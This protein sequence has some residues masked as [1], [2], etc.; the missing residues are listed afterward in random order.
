MMSRTRAA[1][2]AVMM[3][4]VLGAGLMAGSAQA[5]T[6]SFTYQLSQTANIP[7]MPIL[8]LRAGGLAL[9]D[10]NGDGLMDAVA[11]GTYVAGVAIIPNGGPET[12]INAGAGPA[13]VAAADLDGDG[14]VDLVVCERYDD[15]VAVYSNDGFGGFVR[16]GFYRTGSSVETPLGPCAVLAVDIELD[17]QIELVVAN[18]SQHS[19]VV[20]DWDGTGYSVSQKVTFPPVAEPCAL[21]AADLGGSGGPDIAVACAGTDRVRILLNGNGHL[22]PGPIYEAGPYP[23]AVAAADLDGSGTTDLV[24]A[25]REAP[26]VTVLLHDVGTLFNVVEVPLGPADSAFEPPTDV[27]LADV[28]F[29]GYVDIRCAGKTL[30]NDG[31]ANFTLLESGA[32]AGAVYAKGM[33]A[34]EPNEF[35]GVVYRPASG[36]NIVTVAYNVAGDTNGDGHVDVVDLLTLVDSFGLSSGDPGF[37]P[38]ADINRDGSVDVVDLLL[39][40]DNFGV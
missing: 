5:D 22:W 33:L 37:D 2:Y 6:S 27:Q 28:N 23:V 14:D 9:A 26:Q 8:P 16:S 38:A 34:G 10:L 35:L 17:G 39:L 20:M 24:V 15:G 4:F 3:T 19:V 25:N 31:A 7:Y 32:L 21:V 1:R 29:D 11:A 18:R 12:W 40:V 36:T 30:L 13:A